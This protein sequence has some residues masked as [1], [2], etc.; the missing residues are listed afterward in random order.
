VNEGTLALYQRETISLVPLTVVNRIAVPG[1]LVVGDGT[2]AAV[3]RFNVED[4][5]ANTGHR[6][7]GWRTRSCGSTTTTTR[8]TTSSCAAAL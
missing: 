3:V 8:S 5:I 4:Q 1:D 7:R 2:N 6:D